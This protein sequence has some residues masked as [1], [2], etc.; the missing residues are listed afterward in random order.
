MSELCDLVYVSFVRYVYNFIENAV[1]F[2]CY[3]A[4]TTRI[5]GHPLSPECSCLLAFGV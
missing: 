1:V 2:V 3:D 4:C 5:N